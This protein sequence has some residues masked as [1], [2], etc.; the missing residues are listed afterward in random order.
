M[1]LYITPPPDRGQAALIPVLAWPFLMFQNLF[2]NIADGQRWL[3][4]ETARII[5]FIASGDW[6]D[7]EFERVFPGPAWSS[8][9]QVDQDGVASGTLG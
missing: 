5:S 1:N 2:A 6:P 4:H 7:A 8:W 3:H 9:P